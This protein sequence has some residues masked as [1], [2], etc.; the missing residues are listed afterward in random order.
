MQ[1]LCRTPRL[2][3]EGKLRTF[4]SAILDIKYRN[5]NILDVLDMTVK[6]ALSYF[7][8][9]PRIVDKLPTSSTKS[10]PQLRPPRPVRH[11]PSPAAE[12]ERVH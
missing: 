9:H 7:A 4:P 3:Y 2:P 6:E 1:F 11:P 10:A 5:K 8:G 12:A